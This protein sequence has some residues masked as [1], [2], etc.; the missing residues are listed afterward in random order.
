MDECNYDFDISRTTGYGL[1]PSNMWQSTVYNPLLT[2]S[3][4]CQSKFP[5]YHTP[6]TDNMPYPYRSTGCC[7]IV[8]SGEVDYHTDEDN[9]KIFGYTKYCGDD[10][11]DSNEV[12]DGNYLGTCADYANLPNGHT[13]PLGFTYTGAPACTNTC[14]VINATAPY[15]NC[16]LPAVGYYYLD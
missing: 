4:W 11:I 1:P 8:K 9:V 14:T 13:C 3:I 6:V 16:T 15:C 10:I 12:C 5:N 7:L 2:P